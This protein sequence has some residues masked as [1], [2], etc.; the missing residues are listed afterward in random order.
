MKNYASNICRT[1][2]GLANV[3][4]ERSIV[5]I[6]FRQK[7]KILLLILG[8]WCLSGFE[9]LEGKTLNYTKIEI[10]IHHLFN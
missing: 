1:H 3:K 2:G 9:N 4:S 8:D 7:C 6:E 5:V 10:N